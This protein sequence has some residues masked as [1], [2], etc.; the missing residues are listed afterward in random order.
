M[1]EAWNMTDP[2]VLTEIGLRIARHR[3]GRNLTQAQLAREAGVSTRTL[4]RLEGGQP[5]Q[6][7]SLIRVLRV[8]GL[9]GNLDAFLPPAVPNPVEVLRS[10]GKPRRRASGR[11]REHEGTGDWTWADEDDRPGD[12]EDDA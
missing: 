5:S 4:E 3:L 7:T 12:R 10:R 8:L 1:S 9:L 2:A 6:L 11:T